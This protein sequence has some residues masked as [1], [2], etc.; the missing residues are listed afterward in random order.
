VLA[1][2]VLF[3]TCYWRVLRRLHCASLERYHSAQGRRTQPSARNHY[4][5]PREESGYLRRPQYVVSG[6]L[7]AEGF[8]NVVY[9]RSIEMRAHLISGL[10]RDML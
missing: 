6:L 2:K 9:S 7:N 5:P 1:I 8:T 3:A 4:N 10:A